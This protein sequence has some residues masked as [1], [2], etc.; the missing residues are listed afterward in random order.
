MWPGSALAQHK[1][2][3]SDLPVGSRRLCFNCA[4][5]ARRADWMAQELQHS[6]SLRPDTHRT[7]SV[8]SCAP[9][10]AVHT[11]PDPPQGLTLRIPHE[12][13]P[14]WPTLKASSQV[15]SVLNL[16]YKLDGHQCTF[17]TSKTTPKHLF[18]AFMVY[19]Y[20]FDMFQNIMLFL[21]D[22]QPGCG[23]VSRSWLASKQ[24][25]GIAP[26]RSHFRVV[27]VADFLTLAT[28]RLVLFSSTGC[29]DMLVNL[30]ITGL[31]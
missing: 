1:L 28:A 25:W 31:L 3:H 11:G 7:P 2:Y 24:R 4:A 17:L 14:F 13:S 10:A 29:D 5:A 20:N 16:K 8:K 22:T 6:G 12:L 30:K 27:Y 15:Y 21:L 9:Q 19:E 18:S 26:H 23:C